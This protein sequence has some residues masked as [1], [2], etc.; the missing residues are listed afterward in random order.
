MA[1]QLPS[2][3]GKIISISGPVVTASNMSGSFMY[4]VIRV[5]ESR[6]IGEIIRLKADTA[7][8]QV[9]EETSGLQVGENVFK[10]GKLLSVHLGPGLLSRVFDGIQ[11]N[12][13]TIREASGSVF[14]PRGIVVPALNP[15]TLWDLRTSM[16][17]GDL[18]SVGDIFGVITENQLLDSRII[19]PS[20]GYVLRP[21]GPEYAG[22][23]ARLEKLVALGAR[24]STIGQA[25]Y[26]AEC[27]MLVDE[28]HLSFADKFEKINLHGGRIVYIKEALRGAS[29]NNL[30]VNE[31]SL[32]VEG[33]RATSAARPT[34]VFYTLSH[35]HPVRTP[36][37]YA[38]KALPSMP[39]LTGQRVLDGVFPLSVGSC[40]A[41]PGA[42]GC[43]KTVVS[44]SISK[45]SNTDIIVYVGC[46]ERGN[47][48]AEVLKDFPEMTVEKN[49]KQC[50]IMD[51]TILI[52]NT[53]NM[54]VAARE[55]SIY[56]GVTISEYYRD[57][58]YAVC[59]L[60]DSTSRWAEALREISGRLSELPSEGGYPSNLGMKIAHFYERA[61]VVGCLGGNRVVAGSSVE[62]GVDETGHEPGT[63]IAGP[64]TGSVSI[65]GAVSPAA[66]DL[67]DAV[68][69][70]TLSIVQVFWGLSKNLAK[71]KHFPSVD[72]LVS[73]SRCVEG[74]KE[75]YNAKDK[76]FLANRSKVMSLLQEEVGVSESAQLIG[77]ESLSDGDKLII[78][79]CKLIQEGLLQQNSYTA[80]DRFCHFEKTCS[81]MRNI[82]CYYENVKKVLDITAGRVSYA[83][84]KNTLVDINTR[85][86]RM[87]FVNANEKGVEYTVTELDLLNRDIQRV[88]ESLL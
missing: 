87:K 86:Y 67:S 69:V 77:F 37:P 36:R 42:F 15:D 62:T 65:V 82:I 35:H 47:E 88:C 74:T 27:R 70:C 85:L 22:L 71:R 60:A 81:M 56:T 12:L 19:L 32:V 59:L 11:R 76:E 80:F 23:S 29:A 14:I 84:A 5:G 10:T 53:S 73:Y 79:V 44:Q 40:A 16:K 34:Y 72:W 38:T 51:R 33:P 9:Y 64:R 75:W 45:Y 20:Y 18:V 25:E 68:C 55:A 6:L 43:G 28:N 50:P 31:V 30:T 57:Q 2:N 49:G 39:L 46:G 26:D 8:I 58:G 17:V 48:M 13:K 1:T 24:V 41:I 78:D 83:E 3:T 54:P 52:A 63:V 66:G 4:E 61:G 7:I 21:D